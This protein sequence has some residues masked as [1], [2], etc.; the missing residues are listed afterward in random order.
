MQFKLSGAQAGLA[1]GG[2][3]FSLNFSTSARLRGAFSLKAL[4]SALERL[5][6]IHPLMAVR[7]DPGSQNSQPCFTTEAV[8]PVP[9]RVMERQTDQDWV[10]EVEREIA[11]PSN[12]L[13][14][15]LF[16]CVWLR[17]QEVSD[18][19]LVSD[20]ITADGFAGIYALRD[21]LT[22]LADPAVKLEP[23]PVERLVDLVPPAMRK[24][25]NEKVS[26]SGE[27]LPPPP[28][29]SEMPASSPLKVIPFEF[30]QEETAALVACC[31][32][33]EV[34]VQAALCMA[35]TLPFAER[36]PEQP[37]RWVETP[38]N[39]RNRLIRPVEN[40]YGV[41]IS[42]AYSQ[43]DCTPGRD[44]WEIARQVGRSLAGVTEEQLF[45]IPIVMMQVAE[46]PL[47]VPVVTFDYDLSISNLGKVTIPS[48]YGDLILESIYAPTM[49]VSMPSHRI[50][51]V[52]TFKGSMRCTFTSRDSQASRL[53]RRSREILGELINQPEKGAYRD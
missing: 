18:L 13:V 1:K 36:Q 9:L 32:R 47:T 45:S 12:Y 53:V 3:P 5:R 7:I 8:P 27:I 28:E 23:C 44:R 35:F 40:V 34:T 22:I 46:R 50:L 6:Y 19:I 10:R 33:E 29:F 43:V 17:G 30:S 20:H 39:L 11:E 25:I 49:N 31:R 21:L 42:L 41:F 26:T 38:Y 48:C 2:I 4:E 14:G 15:P 16:R 37:L 24:M 51:G 52:T